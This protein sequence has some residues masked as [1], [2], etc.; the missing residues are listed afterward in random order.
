MREPQVWTKGVSMLS[1]GRPVAIA[2]LDDEQFSIDVREKFF[3]IMR[4][5]TAMEGRALARRLY[6][7]P[8]TYLNW[9]YGRNFPGWEI[10]I[11]VIR[12][13]ELGRQMDMRKH[14]SFGVL[15]IR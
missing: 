4:E 8:N 6:R 3:T 1:G 9:K 15:D 2:R 10:A 11:R 7:S 13:N 5:V 12:W 14:E